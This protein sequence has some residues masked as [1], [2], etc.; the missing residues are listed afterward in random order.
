LT[1]PEPGRT[2]SEGDLAR[3]AERRER[4]D[5]EYNDA[6]TRLNE[7][8]WRPPDFPHPPPGPDETQVTPLNERWEILRARPG[9]G[10]RGW[11]HR[12][13]RA[14][15]KPV[16][17]EQQAFNSLLVDHINRSIPQQ[18]ETARS[19]ES[20][21]AVLRQQVEQVCA[22]NLQ[23]MHYLQRVTAFVDS[24]DYEQAALALRRHEDAQ[25]LL[26]GLTAA[27]HELSNHFQMHVESL[28]ARA[29]RYDARIDATTAAAAIVQQQVA[30]LRREVDKLSAAIDGLALRT[31]EP[32]DTAVPEAGPA[33]PDT[34]APGELRDRS[35]ADAGGARAHSGRET[36]DRRAGAA[37]TVRAAEGAN[38]DRSATLA[39]DS[40]LES[41]KY[42]AF[43]A[44]FRGTPEEVTRRLEEYVPIFAG[45]SDVLDVGCGRG[46][47]L[48]LL[49]GAGVSG[50]GIDLNHEMVE[51]CRARGLDVA[52][53][54]ALA[55][56]RGLPDAS[57]GGLFAAQVVEHLPPD[58]LL[59]FLDEA[60]RALR[61]GAAIVLETI[62][63]A[64]WYAFF[65]SYIR[66][67]THARPLHP[68][69]LQYLVTAS[70][71]AGAEIRYRVPLQEAERL[72]RVPGPVW[73]AGG[74][75]GG[76]LVELGR[77]VEHNVQLLNR[78]LFSS[79]DYAVVAR[80]P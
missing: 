62:N 54:D 12:M 58:Y 2:V 15:L 80:R 57:L 1:L 72:Q 22:F 41:W 76:A 68:E 29:Q 49:R 19:I 47:F 13:V 56:L 53:A 67:I 8:L 11:L 42:P 28:T 59:A 48:D 44:V 43:E 55:Y 20:T 33:P 70:G 7:A 45:A 17:A 34:A 5:A 6:L 38:L 73:Q 32:S 25:I 66:D 46:E 79:M 10:W 18:R 21:I 35:P 50:R 71:F 31:R 26:H 30:A 4:S 51:L 3:L 37:A 16:L 36:R 77:A 63:V 9:R 64:C 14:L 74:E 23:L 24:K 75:A 65:Q 69:T 27:V 60:L 78:L 52:R 61:P 40:P 39:G